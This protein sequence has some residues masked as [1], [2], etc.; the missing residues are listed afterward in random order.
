MLVIYVIFSPPHPPHAPS[1]LAARTFSQP[2]PTKISRYAF[3]ASGDLFFLLRMAS[4]VTSALVPREPVV[5]CRDLGN[6]AESQLTTSTDVATLPRQAIGAP[7]ELP[8]LLSRFY[9]DVA[10]DTTA[11]RRLFVSGS[12]RTLDLSTWRSNREDPNT[13]TRFPCFDLVLSGSLTSRARDISV[14]RQSLPFALM[15]L[16]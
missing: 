8:A 14:D 10:G 7:C 6:N 2:C 4:L 5:S 12:V 16:V 3:L 15:V 9:A 11:S 1:P 13:I